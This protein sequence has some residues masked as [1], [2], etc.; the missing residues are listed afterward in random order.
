MAWEMSLEEQFVDRDVLET[1]LSLV[2]QFQNPIYK[3]K[4]ISVREDAHD[5]FDLE[6]FG[7]LRVCLQHCAHQSDS[8]AVARLVCGDASTHAS[9]GQRKIADAVQRFVPNEFVWESQ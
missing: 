6:H 3:E 1:D 7:L 2:G 9:A 5:F 8:P 4:W